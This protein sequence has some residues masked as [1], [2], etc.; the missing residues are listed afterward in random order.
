MSIFFSATIT[1]P[2]FSFSIA[3]SSDPYV[4]FSSAATFPLPSSSSTFSSDPYLLFLLGCRLPITFLFLS[5]LFQAL[6]SISHQ[7]PPSHCLPFTILQPSSFPCVP[8]LV[9]SL[10][11]LFLFFYIPCC[12]SSLL[13]LFFQFFYDC[14]FYYCSYFYLCSFSS[15]VLISSVSFHIPRCL[16]CHLW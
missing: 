2:L 5:V 15:V 11:L 13:W 1:F 10:S 9:L 6:S 7:L 16:C 8:F 4:L 12:Y 14:F 3:S